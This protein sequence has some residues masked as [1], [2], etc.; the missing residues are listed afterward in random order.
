MWV[1]KCKLGFLL[2]ER[3]RL[4]LSWKYSDLSLR[5]VTIDKKELALFLPGKAGL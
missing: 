5:F 1:V 2:G 3:K 4:S